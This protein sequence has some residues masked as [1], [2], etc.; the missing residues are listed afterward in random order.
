MQK[1]PIRFLH[2]DSS[3]DECAGASKDLGRLL[4]FRNLERRQSVETI[5]MNKAR[6][7]VRTLEDIYNSI[8]YKKETIGIRER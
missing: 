3:N 4:R 1:E 2:R 7:P 6:V 8:V 5:P